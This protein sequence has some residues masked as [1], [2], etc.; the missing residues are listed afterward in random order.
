MVTDFSDIAK[1]ALDL[2][3]TLLEEQNRE[4]GYW[5]GQ[6]AEPSLRQTCHALEALHLLD[7]GAMDQ[8]IEEGLDWLIGLSNGPD[9]HDDDRDVQRLHPSRFKTLFWLGIYD[10][11]TIGTEFDE[12]RHHLNAN[13]IVQDVLRKPLLATIIY[14]DCL[15]Q[16]QRVLALPLPVSLLETQIA[17]L[18]SIRQHL[19]QWHI[20]ASPSNG[21][22]QFSTIGDVSYALDLLLRY[23]QLTVTD[24]I[25]EHVCQD[26]LNVLTPPSAAR[27][28]ST[29][30]LYAAIQLATYF[31]ESSQVSNALETF[32][33]GLLSA[34]LHDL[35][36]EVESFQPLVLRALSTFYGKRL[37]DG[38]DKFLLEGRRQQLDLERKSDTRLLYSTFEQLLKARFAVE[39]T[40]V[41][42][43]SGG[44]TRDKVY[45]IN[46]VLKLTSTGDGG[47][48]ATTIYAPNP[49]SLVVKVGS[50]DSLRSSV[51]KYQHLP[52]VVRPVFARHSDIPQILEANSLAPAYLILED[53]THLYETFQD[54]FTKLELRVANHA[55]RVQRDDLQIACATIASGLT[56]LYSRTRKRETEFFGAQ[57]SRLY[58]GRVEKALNAI[59]H[60]NKFPHLKP[61]FGGFQL[62]TRKYRSIEHYL[63][64]LDNYKKTKLK[65]S[66]LTLTHGDCH[67]RNL[68]L[69]GELRH[70]K[71]IDLD[72]MDYDGD[73]MLDFAQLIEDIA[74]FRFLFDKQ[75]R[76]A[77]AAKQIDF[78]TESHDP[79]A[80]ENRIT[81]P[82]FSS[83]AVRDFQTILLGHIQTFALQIEDTTW[84]ERLWLAL[85]V[86]L[87]G[88]VD[89]HD[90]KAYAT[91]LYVEAIKLL[92]ELVACLEDEIPLR[93]IPFSDSHSGQQM[94]LNLAGAP[95]AHLA[96]PLLSELHQYLVTLGADVRSNARSGNPVI[97]YFRN[98]ARTPFA[99]LDGTRQP[100][101][102][103]LAGNPDTLLDVNSLAKQTDANGALCIVVHL[104][105]SVRVQDVIAL[106]QQV[107]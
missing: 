104:E 54:I 84:K 53:L 65:I 85:A 81:Y 42:P 43:L 63:A 75:F 86:H 102:L 13:G 70:L 100:A 30:M 78:V 41:K 2:V 40:D 57:L 23:E 46:F 9:A 5:P 48:P 92:D 52:P 50:L 4:A 60:P 59:C 7:W 56:D 62:G 39:V 12:L 55:Y 66:T 97:R 67:S 72:K 80:I 3:L 26:M 79:K 64:K 88:L 16:L 37:R 94:A 31:R 15:Y 49:P 90:E 83:V 101:Q 1:F 32:F 76:Y 51:E 33:Q 71:L 18:D 17:A 36:G 89:K 8:P 20:G 69:D 99:I 105:P 28:I 14:L 10:E 47:A 34:N 96:Y 22:K 29:D 58:I 93:P 103:F 106:V 77:L 68:M 73:Y 61:W 87:L 25:A 35:K 11:F 19:T 27:Q 91:V 98:E 24:P 21:Q 6:Q 95:F 74:V 38:M 44:L 82:A 45:R 107:I